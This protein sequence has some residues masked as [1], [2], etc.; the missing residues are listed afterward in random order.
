MHSGIVRLK[1]LEREGL[2]QH[3]SSIRGGLLGEY[4][5]YLEEDVIRCHGHDIPQV[6]MLPDLPLEP[7]RSGWQI[8]DGRLANAERSTWRQPALGF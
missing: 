8:R 4:L 6:P 2:R 5:E 3:L 7:W 1:G